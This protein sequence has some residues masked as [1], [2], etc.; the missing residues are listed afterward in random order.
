MVKHIVIFK[1]TPPYSG[2][3][4]EEGLQQLQDIFGPLGEKLGFPVEYHTGINILNADY[5]G[6]F[7]I[8]SLFDSAEDLRRYQSSPEHIEAVSKAS[9]V[10]KTKTVVDYEL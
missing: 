6:D 9:S 10:R 5:A 8:D 4:K 3:E 7:V 2:E 1:L